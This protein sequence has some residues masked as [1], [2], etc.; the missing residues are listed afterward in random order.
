[1]NP[2]ES[3]LNILQLDQLDECMYQ[4]HTIDI[5]S[6]SVF[7]GQVLAQALHAATRTVPDDRL[8]HSLHGYFILPG[9][10]QE[11]IR[12]EVDPIRDGRSF[13]TRRVVAFQKDRAIFNMAASYQLEQE[14]LD[15]QIEML[16]VPP[17][18]SLTSYSEIFKRF[19]KEFNYKPFGLFDPE[20]P[21]EVRPVEDI[22]PFNPGKRRP[23]RHLWFRSRNALPDDKRI[24]REV[25]AYASDFNLLITAILPHDVQLFQGK[26]K[27]ASIDHAMWFH[28][29]FRAD[30]WLLYAIDSPSASNA[31]GFCRGSIFTRDGRLVASVTQEGLIR[32]VE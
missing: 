12:Y 17:P 5:G 9:D 27:M 3:L 20:A 19:A 13:T 6:R 16:N 10:I 26:L 18:E 32:L 31:R 22:N 15:H 21:I 2:T 23:F 1:M 14:G 24:H 8:V 4:G 25:M 29:D 28:R 11:P 30:E 7:G